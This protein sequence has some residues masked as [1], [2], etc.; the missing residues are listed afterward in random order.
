[1]ENALIQKYCKNC[2]TIKNIN[3][4]YKTKNNKDYPDCRIN[5]CKPCMKEYKKKNDKIIEE[6]PHYR[7]EQREIV[8]FF[9]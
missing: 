3:D 7:V 6:K 8:M 4:F 9:D 5:W 2:S 1:M